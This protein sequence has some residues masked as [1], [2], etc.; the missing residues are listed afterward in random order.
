MRERDCLKPLI[1]MQ[2]VIQIWPF[3]H[4]IYSKCIG[5]E[6]LHEGVILQKNIFF[7]CLFVTPAFIFVIPMK[8]DT[9]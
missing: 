9:Y 3:L 2:S 7:F 6:Q 4:N 1:K 8:F 5:L